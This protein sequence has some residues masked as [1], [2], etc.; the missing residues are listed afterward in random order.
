MLATKRQDVQSSSSICD[1]KKVVDV[2]ITIV[3]VA[4]LH[5]HEAA[6]GG[7]NNANETT[8]I[9]SVSPSG[10]SPISRH[11][12]P[13]QTDTPLG[14]IQWSS[15]D[16]Y[17][18]IKF[19]E[20]FKDTRHLL[21]SCSIDLSIARDGRCYPLGI[22]NLVI[23][24]EDL[25]MNTLHVPID[26]VYPVKSKMFS[27]KK[28]DVPM[29]KPEDETC[30]FGLA[31]DATMRLIVQVENVSSK[32]PSL[33]YESSRSIFSFNTRDNSSRSS[34]S[35]ITVT[36]FSALCSRQDDMSVG[37]LCFDDAKSFNVM[38]EISGLTSYWYDNMDKSLPSASSSSMDET[39]ETILGTDSESD[40]CLNDLDDDS[41]P[42]QYG[43]EV[44]PYRPRVTFGPVEEF[45][46]TVEM[47]NRVLVTLPS[48]R[49]A[50]LNDEG[51]D[52]SSAA[53]RKG[54]LWTRG[55]KQCM[56]S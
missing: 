40:V 20:H 45:S 39:V 13:V 55:W 44:V 16:S 29:F 19:R 53:N 50:M 11:S 36:E 43:V 41:L 30:R 9:A 22:S 27:L 15:N 26:R 31:F 42:S 18:S 54:S 4:G 12:S 17:K 51:I 52:E 47:P 46:F 14:V 32:I 23:N 6:A 49:A 8:I 38:R 56:L 3:S 2:T 21:S 48:K 35:K 37:T 5:I 25:E 1:Y 24:G 7:I 33:N 34:N 10:Q 28:N